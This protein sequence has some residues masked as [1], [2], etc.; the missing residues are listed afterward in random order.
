MKAVYSSPEVRELTR[1]PQCDVP[2]GSIHEDGCSIERC[3]LCGQQSIGCN[4]VRRIAG[5]HDD[6]FEDV[7]TTEEHWALF[8]AEAAKYGGRLPY[9]GEYPGRRECRKFGW[10]SYF[11]EKTSRWVRCDKDHP[12]AHEDL[13]RLY[14][15]GRATWNK[16]KRTWELTG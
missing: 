2:P 15:W 8:D 5:I 7:E 6:E 9:S 13:G 11:D 16:E 12:G 3:A 1:C 14:G 10:Y 4:C